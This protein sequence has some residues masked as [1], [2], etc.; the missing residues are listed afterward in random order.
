MMGRVNPFFEKAGMTA[1]SAP[2]PAR[3]VRLIEALGMIGVKQND[4]IDPRG[5]QRRMENLQPSEKKF[6]AQET[7]RFL[8]TYGKR[9]HMPDGFDRTRFIL[10]KLTDRP[11]Y[12]IW[13]SPEDKLNIKN[14]NA[15]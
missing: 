5:V 6:I 12:Y 11:V 10:T 13:F 3:C 9:R 4:L 15:K 14:Q 8:Q 1:C 2:V 7:D